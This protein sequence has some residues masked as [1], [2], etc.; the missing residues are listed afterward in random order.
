MVYHG[1]NIDPTAN[2]IVHISQMTLDEN[3]NYSYSF[4]PKFP[5]GYNGTGDF[6]VV[7]SLEGSTTPVY[8]TTIEALKPS[9]SVTFIEEDGTEIDT[10]RVIEGQTAI[11]PEPPEKEGYVFVGWNV[12]V[13]NIRTDMTIVARY[14]KK[15]YSVLFINWDEEELAVRTFQ[16]GDPITLDKI[17]EKFGGVFA[18]WQT[19]DGNV[20]DS[21]TENL[22]LTAKFDTASY[23]VNFYD[24]DGNLLDTQAVTFGEDAVVPAAAPV[25]KGLSF[26]NWSANA[27]SV[28]QDMEI[29]PVY[30][31]EQ[32]VDRPV[33]KIKTADELRT[34]ELTCSTP[35]AEIYYITQNL[36]EELGVFDYF[37]DPFEYD[38]NGV[39][40][41]GTL[42]T[43]PVP[44]SENTL[45]FFIAVKDGMNRSELVVTGYHAGSA[46]TPG[47]INNDG[48]VNA[49]D[50]TMLR[51]YLAGGFEGEEYDYINDISADCNGDG[52]VDAKDITRLR[53]YLAGGWV[54]DSTLG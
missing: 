28:M 25:Y 13:T 18:G 51:R 53:R 48:E 24:A 20:V 22:V 10:Q 47:D 9:Y 17:P 31:F 39:P 49:K 26:R 33:A 7:I 21:V 3:G 4:V 43:E 30:G 41:N 14:E 15:E 23:T 29:Y 19:A 44:L 32:T 42:Y 45:I 37:E 52:F 16:Y 1:T 8:I 35:G 11:M 38:E 36:S 2:Q 54:N 40:S 46:F 12:S 34:A 27:D 5:V 50:V 6:I